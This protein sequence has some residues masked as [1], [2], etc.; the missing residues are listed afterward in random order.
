MK[1]L[2]PLLA[3]ILGL[4]PAAAAQPR[5]RLEIAP[6]V[7]ADRVFIEGDLTGV[8]SVVGVAG[9]WR[10]SK[11]LGVE[12]EITRAFNRMERSYEG[13]F[14]SYVEDPN[15]TREEIEALAPIAR[16][17]LGYEP[18]IGLAAA[19]V[20]RG[21]L[22]P[23]VTIA[24]RAGVAPR[25]YLE[26]SDYTVLS[27]P[28]GADPERVARD[29]QDSSRTRTRGGFLLGVDVSVAVTDRF[30]VAPEF[31]FVYSGPAR[32]GDKHRELGLGV[33]GGWRF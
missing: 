17:T 29:F 28:P 10:F 15:A 21:E 8:T 25:W 1:V 9:T 4:A 2:L 22:S 27:I 18:G 20:A 31:R 6:V 33:R 14:I 7:R 12:G 19:F 32:I 11:A 5:S 30:T 16:R 3:A 23:R 13:W 24:G 26:T